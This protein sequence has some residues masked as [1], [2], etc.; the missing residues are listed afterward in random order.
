MK[1]KNVKQLI[2]YYIESDALT[3]ELSIRLASDKDAFVL[4]TCLFTMETCSYVY[5]YRIDA[6]GDKKYLP[7]ISYNTARTQ[8]IKHPY[9][10]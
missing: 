9:N 5:V 2:R 10:S 1:R 3:D 4:S 8:Q 7:N 6:I